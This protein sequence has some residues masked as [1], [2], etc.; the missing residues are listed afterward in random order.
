MCGGG[1]GDSK[2]KTTETEKAAADVAVQEYDFARKMDGVKSE[3]ESRIERLGTEGYRDYTK[4]KV[5][6][7]AVAGRG[8]ASESVDESLR[9]RG[10]DPSSGASSSVRSDLSAAAGDSI[11]RGKGEAEFS[12]DTAYLGGKSNRVKMALGE[13][14]EAVV[15]LNDIANI[16]NQE[17]INES[18]SKFNSSTFIHYRVF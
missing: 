6:R 16:S 7:K 5:G 10:V 18:Y 2:P 13:K 4:A 15:G 3:Y 8:V 11:G 9:A 17:S 1:G 14:T 12:A